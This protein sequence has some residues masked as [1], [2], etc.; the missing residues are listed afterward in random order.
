MKIINYCYDDYANFMHEI[1]RAM[2]FVGMDA[3]DYIVNRH[4]YG[5]PEEG[6]PIKPDDL[7]LV[8]H[9][10]D[11]IQIFHS[12]ESALADVKKFMKPSQLLIVWHTGTRY[13]QRFLHFNNVFKNVSASVFALP[14]LYNIGGST[15]PYF[16]MGC[17]DT[18]MLELMKK[19]V[20]S[21]VVKIGHFPSNYETKK[22]DAIR[23]IF[24]AIDEQK[25]P[26]N[27]TYISTVQLPWMDSLT[28]MAECD[29]Y[30]ELMAPEQHGKPYGSFGITAL[31]AAAMGIPVITMCNR[32]DTYSHFYKQN[33]FHFVRNEQEAVEVLN[34]LIKRVRNH[35]VDWSV[36]V[37]SLMLTTHS[38]PATGE[39]IKKMITDELHR[40]QGKAATV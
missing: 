40:I 14:E 4:S 19:P 22:T 5:Y 10:A 12:D 18:A 1:T 31:E 27:I 28:R 13:R 33:P 32:N 29:I 25:N 16:I 26:N 36:L 9:D 8:A 3:Y 20:N 35:Q 2:L 34:Y 11:V 37:R 6:K 39:R 15:N 21:Q 7:R 38:Y 24:S 30:F 17:V 23:T